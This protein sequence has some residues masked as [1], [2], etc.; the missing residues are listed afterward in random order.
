MILN[1]PENIG[2]SHIYSLDGSAHQTKIQDG[3]LVI[4]VPP[5]IFRALLA[6]AQGKLWHDLNG[7]AL[8]LLAV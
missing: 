3:V 2:L 8:R 4:D 6:G 1:V 7:D 5:N